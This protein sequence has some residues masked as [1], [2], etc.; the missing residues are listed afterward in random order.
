[1]QAEQIANQQKLEFMLQEHMLKMETK[2]EEANLKL[3]T[4]AAQAA[5]KREEKEDGKSTSSD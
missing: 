1:M 4:T 3:E 2:R 5:M